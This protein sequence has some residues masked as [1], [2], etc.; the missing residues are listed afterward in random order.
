M[1]ERLALVRQAPQRV[2]DASLDRPAGGDALAHARPD[3]ERVWLQ[4]DGVRHAQVA[5]A[6]WWRAA[7]TT[8]ARTGRP[9]PAIGPAQAQG[10]QADLLWA[11]MCLHLADDPLAALRSWRRMVGPQGFL[12]F[13][14][15]GPGSLE[16]LR[17]LYRDLGWGPAHAPFTDMHDLGD[18][19][20]ETGW[21]DP[22]M[23]QETLNLH[24]GSAEQ[25]LDELVELGANADPA[26][27]A[28]LRTPRGRARLL[29]ALAERRDAQGRIAL[30]WELVY[31]HAFQAPP[32]GP[33]VA[34]ETQIA[35]GDM[36]RLLRR[37]R[38]P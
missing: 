17:R 2:L 15:L 5:Q 24:E 37:P 34:A 26:R 3:A 13:T 38:H 18:M 7:W 22:V 9:V 19:L 14:T 32:K 30:Q 6:P 36:R 20:V 10:W 29:S 35:L 21:A 11:N 28:G 4:S 8:W 23:D 16:D 25:R 31:G 27:F 12:M 1:A 33:A